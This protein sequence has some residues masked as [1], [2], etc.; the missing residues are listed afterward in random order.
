MHNKISRADTAFDLG[1]DSAI[2]F[3]SSGEVT[4]GL[5]QTFTLCDVRGTNYAKGL[6]IGP[7]GRPRPTETA[8]TC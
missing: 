5:G 4:N 6:I 2:T 1:A 3:R 7:T 8:L